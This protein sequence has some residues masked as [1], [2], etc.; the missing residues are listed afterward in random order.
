MSQGKLFDIAPTG[1]AQK[2][3]RPGAHVDKEKADLR[4]Y[5]HERLAKYPEFIIDARA[6]TIEISYPNFLSIPRGDQRY[7]VRILM[8][9]G[10]QVQYS[11]FNAEQSARN[12]KKKGDKC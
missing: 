10:Y 8:A 12:H 3:E 6:N 1:T 4:Y 11:I 5:H 2:K 9:L 7:S